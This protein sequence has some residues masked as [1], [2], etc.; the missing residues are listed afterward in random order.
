[1]VKLLSILSL[2]LALV[3]FPPAALAV[4]SNNAVPGDA[5]YPIKRSLEN[6][7][8]AIASL[9]PNTKAWF[10]AAR[11]DRR[12]TEVKTL[13]AEGKVADQSLQELVTQTQVAAIQINEVSD[14]LKKQELINN[15]SDS[16]QKYNLGLSQASQQI[17]RN[18][19]VASPVPQVIQPTSTSQPVTQPNPTTKVVSQ[20][21]SVPAFQPT[22]APVPTPVSTS[23]SPTA[24]PI[25]NPVFTPAPTPSPVVSTQ[26]DQINQA[27]DELKKIE[28]QLKTKK[29]A[30]PSVKENKEEDKTKKQ[31]NQNNSEKDKKDENRKNNPKQNKD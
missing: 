10:S 17:N 2:I 6:I 27:I 31:D 1:M 30:P 15:L 29:N 23:T 21:S 25:Q 9:N 5:T 8:F 16:I 12:F 28:E 20:A 24:P 26:P 22:V 7:I 4:I 19:Q 13:L 18:P 11:S 14:P 3:L